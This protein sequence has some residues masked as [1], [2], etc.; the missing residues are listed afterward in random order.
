M[1]QWF[2]DIQCK[3]KKTTFLDND[4]NLCEI[5]TGN[6]TELSKCMTMQKLFSCRSE[7]QDGN[8]GAT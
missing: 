1:V 4:Q 6:I 3:L 7:I 5:S 2:L 8:H